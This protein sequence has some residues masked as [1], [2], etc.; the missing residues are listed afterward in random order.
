M[1]F[2][3]LILARLLPIGQLYYNRSVTEGIVLEPG[4]DLAA[5]QAQL[6]GLERLFRAALDGEVADSRLLAAGLAEL[7][8]LVARTAEQVEGWTVL[9]AAQ[10]RARREGWRAV[11]VYV[12]RL[13][14]EVVGPAVTVPRL[15]AGWVRGGSYPEL[16]ARL[17]ALL[18]R[19]ESALLVLARAPDPSTSREVQTW[20]DFGWVE[21]P[22]GYFSMGSNPRRDRYAHD[23]EQP[24]HRLYLPAFRLAKVPV[25]AGQ[26][27]VFVRETGFRTAAEAEQS[28]QCWESPHGLQGHGLAEQVDHPVTC[29]S[30][31]DAQAFCRWAG[32]RLPTEAEWEKAA[33]GTDGRLY[34]WGDE[35]PDPRRCNYGNLLGDTTPVG[36]C[37]AGA[38][39]YGALDMAGNV[40]EWTASLWGSLEQGNYRY[41][42]D[43]ADGREAPDA[44]ESLMRIVRGGSF[45]DDGTRMRCAYRDW[46]YPFYRSDAIGFRVVAID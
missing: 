33:R 39:S 29:V 9:P 28:Q 2:R 44:A 43:P 34:P 17:R 37:L 20:L 26:F 19:I 35:L 25:T 38:S 24:Q 45:R 22:A 13:V 11:L 46:R 15:R 1:D 36:S 23:E 7:E 12:G 14:V 4:D 10:G 8:A 27:A 30:W 32:V 5:V 16:S 21:V 41:P 31:H 42:Y 40:W 18:R 6:G 3:P